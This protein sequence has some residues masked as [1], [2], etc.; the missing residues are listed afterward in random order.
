DTFSD[1]KCK[2]LIEK[3]DGTLSQSGCLDSIRFNK[4][5]DSTLKENG[6]FKAQKEECIYNIFQ[7]K[8]HF[9]VS[10]INDVSDSLFKATLQIL[11]EKYANSN[12]YLWAMT[13]YGWYTYSARDMQTALQCYTKAMQLTATLPPS[14][15]IDRANTHKYIGYFLGTINENKMAIEYLTKANSFYDKKNEPKLAA[16][17][18]DNI[19][20]YYGKLKDFEKSESNL[21]SAMVFAKIARDTIRMAK[22]LGNMAQINLYEG[23]LD[24]AIPL[25]EEDIALSIKMKDS[26]NLM[27]AYNLLA[28]V[29]IGKEDAKSANQYL[30]QAL[31]VAETKSFL[32]SDEFDILKKKLSLI[33][34]YGIAGDTTPILL[35][36]SG[37]QDIVDR[38]DGSNALKIA[39]LGFSNSLMMEKRQDMADSLNSERTTKRIYGVFAILLV[40]IVVWVI[41]KYQNNLKKREKDF[42]SMLK[43]LEIEKIESEQKLAK[44]K[45]DV[46]SYVVFLSE[47][48]KQISVLKEELDK[49]KKNISNEPSAW[50]IN[51]IL[52]MHLITEENW[53]H[54][55]D[56]FIQENADFY[57]RL[58]NNYPGLTDSNMRIIFLSKLGLSNQEIANVLRVTYDAVKKA[59]QRLKSKFGI[60]IVDFLM[61]K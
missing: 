23:K 49:Q 31:A 26:L 17:I 16:E 9:L 55:K 12:I 37:L 60:S 7:A 36:M 57:R 59:K 10:S 35:R 56:A 19:S 41:K 6:V 21:D 8:Q 52:D 38:T 3:L 5:L 47:R 54:F 50:K 14:N 58:L 48:N 2:V 20:M 29:Y 25:V 45:Q 28:N 34:Q 11:E 30:N 40:A 13:N 33:R 1:P 18:F 51:Q 43:S 61:E 53:M 15:I 22:V 39:H 24:E 44:A 46:A 42:E 27:F 4:I 32:K